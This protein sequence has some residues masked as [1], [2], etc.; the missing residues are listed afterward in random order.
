M[1]LLALALA[2][3][4]SAPA[5]ADSQ[6]KRSFR[7]LDDDEL[8]AVAR[9]QPG[10]WVDVGETPGH[11]RSMLVPRPAGS[12][13]NTIVR[14]YIQSVFSKLGWHTELDTFTGTTPEGTVEFTNLIFTFDPDA[15]TKFVLAAHHDSKW[16][17]TYPAN[18]F[19]GATDSA[20][21]CAMLLDLAEA[22]TPALK[23]RKTRLAAQRPSTGDSVEDEDG[24]DDFDEQEAAKTTLQFIFFDGEEAFHDWTATDSI[25]GSRHLA[26]EWESTFLPAEHPYQPLAR[27]RMDP[28]PTVLSTIEHLVLLDL[29]GAPQPRIMQWYRETGWLFAE[30][31]DADARLRE[32]G[33]VE[34][35]N[36]GEWFSPLSFG[37][38]IEDDQVPDDAT[39]LDLATMQ[40]WNLILRVFTL[41]YLGLK[42]TK[43]AIG[44][45]QNDKRTAQE[46]SASFQ[47]HELV[48]VS[49]VRWN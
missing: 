24:D 38:S 49:K 12:E 4:L 15:S 19:V 45:E 1:R 40:R 16:F 25:Y 26:A 21:P 22:I 32:S 7:T 41:E 13:N 35:T 33:L 14:E 47:H 31:R 39:A 6:R 28:N 44:R 48:S 17:A 36:K 29:L 20:A 2:L 11:L 3:C 30:M 23:E 10:P 37:G 8:P 42:P 43:A 9:M 34:G 27:R 18:Q 46:S 5:A